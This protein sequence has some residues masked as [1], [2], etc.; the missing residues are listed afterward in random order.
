MEGKGEG[1]GGC[2]GDESEACSDLDSEEGTHRSGEVSSRSRGGGEESSDED[3]DDEDDDEQ[4]VYV[5]PLKKPRLIVSDDEDED[6]NENEDNVP[7]NR[8]D[9][10]TDCKEAAAANAVATEHKPG[11]PGS[12]S[13]KSSVP[14]ISASSS[15]SSTGT[16]ADDVEKRKKGFEVDSSSVLMAFPEEAR[17][18]STESM[19]SLPAITLQQQQKQQK[20]ST[21]LPRTLLS[22]ERTCT[23]SLFAS[24]AHLIGTTTD[25][26][27]DY[28]GGKEEGERVEEPSNGLPA[29]T[30]LSLEEEEQQE[31]GGKGDETSGFF[32][33]Q[34]EHEDRPFGSL[35]ATAS[36]IEEPGREG[37]LD[38]GHLDSG[39][40]VSTAVEEEKEE[41]EE[42]EEGEKD[43]RQS[44][45]VDPDNSSLE[46]CFSAW[47]TSLPPAQIQ[48]METGTPREEEK[49]LLPLDGLT[50]DTQ[51]Q[52]KRLEEDETQVRISTSSLPLH[53]HTL[54]Y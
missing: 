26:R 22:S 19:D 52:H 9:D 51:I 53:A 18:L 5:R 46:T 35:G 49:G 43:D 25:A 24:D 54:R 4:E 41:E 50:V 21:A 23:M 45:T 15:I 42:E 32:S 3:D 40:G 10:K 27:E 28:R 37:R 33:Q 39:V 29:P 36:A 14:F 38:K 47:M 44:L 17:L 12:E 13:T 48:R 20:R 1:E 31:G 11:P 16:K 8:D 34:T 7:P 6:E 2:D 30:S